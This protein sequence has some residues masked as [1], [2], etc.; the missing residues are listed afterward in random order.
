V[1]TAAW[2]EFK[3]ELGSQAASGQHGDLKTIFPKAYSAVEASLASFQ[4]PRFNAFEGNAMEY[5]TSSLWT[6]FVLNLVS[7][8]FML[9]SHCIEF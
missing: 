9:C 4:F 2:E 7:S 6:G 3:V 1:A 5:L 8:I